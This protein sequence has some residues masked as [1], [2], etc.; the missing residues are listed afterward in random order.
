MLILGG[1]RGIGVLIVE[2]LAVNYKSI[3][4]MMGDK[5]FCWKTIAQKIYSK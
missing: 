4:S 5:N 2:V 1:I 3:A